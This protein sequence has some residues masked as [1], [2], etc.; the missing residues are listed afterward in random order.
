LK[1]DTLAGN[2]SYFWHVRATSTGLASPFSKPRGFNVGPQ[3]VIQAPTLLSPANG[4]QSGGSQSTLTVTNASRT[5]PAGQIV[6]RF[7][8]S[9]S[10]AF[11]N[12]IAVM[13]VVEQGG[14]Q[15]T[16]QVSA[17]L[18]TNA[19][20]YWRVLASDPSSGASSPY[21]SVFSFQYVPFDMRQATI[22]SSPSDLG[23]WPATATIT[24]VDLTGDRILVDFDKRD[25][26]NR[27]PDEPFGQGSIEYTLG[28]CLNIN[29]HWNCS[30]VVQF[31]YGR[32]LSAGGGVWRVGIDWFY[33][34]RWGPMAGY[35]QAPGEL[36]GLFVGSGN[37]RGRTDPGYVT[38]PRV[39]ERS[40]V[41]LVPWGTAFSIAGGLRTASS[42][43]R[44]HARP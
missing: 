44:A 24:M 39:C 43:I 40:N 22:W 7:E 9:D 32:E 15:T 5:G 16:A 28:G 34:P 33:G 14:G 29:N 19:T 3:V 8:L 25:G 1:I 12:L 11:T 4:A 30:A 18:T 26:P 20:Y 6:Y 37:L 2:A 38:C 42:R 31:W 27:W 21:S 17:N 13:T 35:Q 10:S 36:V 41:A 23:D